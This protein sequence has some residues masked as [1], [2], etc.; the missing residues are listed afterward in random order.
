VSWLDAT[1][2]RSPV[3][4]QN[5]FATAYGLKER[6][7]RYGGQYQAFVRDLQRSEWWTRDQ[8]QAEQDARLRAMVAHCA[9][10]VRHYRALFRSLG[11][12]EGDIHTAADLHHLPILEKETVRAQPETFRP[13]QLA[14]RALPQ[15]TG[16]TTGTPLHYY[17]TPSAVQYN[18]AAYEARFRVWAGVRFGERL[19]SING[20]V[21][22]P[23]ESEQPPFWRYNLAFNQLYLSGYHM[24]ERNLPH[25][26]AQL[27]RF[28][29]EAIVGYVSTVH[30]LAQH[31]LMS[32]AVGLI[33]PKAVLVSS[34]TLF[35]WIRAD[36]EAAFGCKV[37]NGYSLGELTAFISECPAGS[38]HISPEYGAVEL[39]PIDG[40]LE[41]VATGLFN[42]AMP[43]LRYRTG[44]VVEPASS[45]RC[46]CGRELPLVKAIIG[47][48]DDRVVTPEGTVVGP[49]SL[50]LAFQSVP[51]L[52]AAQ[53][54]QETSAA[55]TVLIAAGG[56][57][58]LAE[59]QLLL[60][61]LRKRLGTT[62]RIE[63]RH[64]AAIPRTSGGKQRLI[65]S[66]LNQ[67]V[68]R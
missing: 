31:M 54:E 22:V 50:S 63:L 23:V 60:A 26:V 21:I 51:K 47:R 32:G 44:D 2:R 46:A 37:Y 66:R 8:L 52:K 4:V 10:E 12:E 27:R 43:L 36:I 1:Y 56:A 9:R 20:K 45:D 7:V 62:L 59:E 49:A 30:A 64:V 65:V 6:A 16:G 57:F 14:E 24:S 53:I 28:R 13:Q 68:R 67:A 58:G 19:A 55:I 18:Y 35:D 39:V 41:L 5:A 38:L 34:E 61:E 42:H 40:N 25:Y 11:L 29:P 17:A 15:T 48:V 3:L 33:Q